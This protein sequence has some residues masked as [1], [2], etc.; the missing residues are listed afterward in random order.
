[1]K[2]EHHP[3]YGNSASY[4][5]DVYL[6]HLA[7]FGHVYAVGDSRETFFPRY[8]MLLS[9]WLRGIGCARH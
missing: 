9:G 2:H 7:V 6:T 4:L 8:G 5:T 1:M 3:L